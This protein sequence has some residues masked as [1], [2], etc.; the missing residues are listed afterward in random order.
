MTSRGKGAR[1]HA[2]ADKRDRALGHASL[3][4]NATE[5]A[6]A[7]AEIQAT[8]DPQTTAERTPQK[9]ASLSCVGEGFRAPSQRSKT[10]PASRGNAGAWEAMQKPG[11]T[12]QGPFSAT[13][14]GAQ[15]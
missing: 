1:T 7:G 9:T 10:T 8:E 12:L 5:P 11:N 15:A 4:G 3:V 14:Q 13:Q 2:E 6:P